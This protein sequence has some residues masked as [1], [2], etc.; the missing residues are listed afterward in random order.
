M[1]SLTEL[2]QKIILLVS[3]VD[4]IEAK[5]KKIDDALLDHHERIIRLEGSAD[6]TAEKAKNAALQGVQVTMTE[7]LK[8]LY[9]VKAQLGAGASSSHA[10]LAA[11]RAAP[12]GDGAT[13][14]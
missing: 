4:K 13:R 9:A 1:A 2:L 3:S 14:E 8:E 10:S 11:P 6:L 12:D 5:I 7:L